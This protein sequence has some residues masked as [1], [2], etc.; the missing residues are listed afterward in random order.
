[1]VIERLADSKEQ[2][3]FACKNLL[4]FMMACYTPG[5]SI[6]YF[7]F[8]AQFIQFNSDFFS[9]YICIIHLKVHLGEIDEL[10]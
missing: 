6:E 4:I 3:R 7:I 8:F 5:V 1:M 9:F 2:V 10:V